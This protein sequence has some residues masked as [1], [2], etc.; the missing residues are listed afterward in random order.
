[1]VPDSDRVL[2]ELLESDELMRAEWM[3]DQKLRNDPRVTRAG[4]ILR[5]TSLDELPQLIN[6]MRG[7]MALVGPRPITLG[8]LERYGRTKWHY[9]AV[10]PG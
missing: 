7:E 9:L 4:R 8:E 5:A 6:V 10:M 3:R 1:M 2:R